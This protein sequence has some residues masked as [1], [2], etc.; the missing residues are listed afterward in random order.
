MGGCSFMGREG[1]GSL[2][3][4]EIFVSTQS[5]ADMGKV[6]GENVSHLRSHRKR[7]SSQFEPLG[8]QKAQAA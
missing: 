2:H 8:I 7:G 1:I 5:R 4:A 6:G 3:L